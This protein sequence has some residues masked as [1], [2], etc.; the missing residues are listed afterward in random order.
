MEYLILHEDAKSRMECKMGFFSSPH[1]R[2]EI[3]RLN[4][5][6]KNKTVEIL[7]LR[8]KI[9]DLEHELEVLKRSV[10]FD[11][12]KYSVNDIVHDRQCLVPDDS[13][14]RIV[15]INGS[16]EVVMEGS[17]GYVTPDRFREYKREL[18]V[19]KLSKEQLFNYLLDKSY[20]MD[21]E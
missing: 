21:R 2:E 6:L 8:K 3:D 4:G 17:K 11:K 16:W 10:Y 12:F 1:D 15:H 7:S 20:V 9:E 14:R 13:L 19:D 18:K 5:E